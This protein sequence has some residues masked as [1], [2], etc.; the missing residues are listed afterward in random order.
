[1]DRQA[2]ARSCRPFLQPQETGCHPTMKQLLVGLWV[3]ESWSDPTKEFGGYSA[4]IC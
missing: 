4:E 1:M 2:G 3:Q